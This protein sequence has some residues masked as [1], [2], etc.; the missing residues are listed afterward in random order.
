MVIALA[1][2]ALA[3]GWPI[4]RGVLRRRAAEDSASARR[5][6]LPWLRPTDPDAL[7][8]LP[9]VAR[10]AVARPAHPDLRAAREVRRRP[11]RSS[12]PS[13]V[14]EQD[15]VSYG[16]LG[17][18]GAIERFDPSREIKFETFAMARIRGAIID[19]L[20]SLDWVPG[21]CAPARARSSARS[22]RSRRSSSRAD[23]RG[24]REEARRHG[25]GAR[26]QPDRD[27][28]LVGRRARRALVA[29]RRR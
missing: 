16:L 11:R 20:R 8:G 19:E 22:L 1:A 24:D 2:A 3:F 21:R 18:I 9:E 6:L 10:P 25:G 13:H 28:A 14:D 7:A 27:L 23:G 12:L 5:I 26:G 15:L 4:S 17:L 29:R